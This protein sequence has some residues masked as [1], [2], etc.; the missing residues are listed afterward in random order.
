[1]THIYCIESS[2]HA[3]ECTL[4]CLK[5]IVVQAESLLK[6]LFLKVIYEI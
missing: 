3:S 6:H 4:S 2:T 5:D 1:M